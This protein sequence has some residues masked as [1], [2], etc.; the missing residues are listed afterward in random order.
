MMRLFGMTA[1]V[2]M[3]LSVPLSV[4]ADDIPP[5][6]EVPQATAPVVAGPLIHPVMS[7]EQLLCMNWCQLEQL[8]RSLK[9]GPMPSGYYRGTVIYGC[10]KMFPK[11]ASKLAGL[12]WKGKHYDL[13]DCTVV[14]QWLVTKAVRARL[15]YGPSRFDGNSSV[16]MDYSGTCFPRWRDV[17][18]ELREVA[19]GLYLGA[20]FYHSRPCSGPSLYFVLETK[21]CGC[22]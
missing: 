1:T 7:K 4:R 3:I 18:D 21:G 5:P 13:C 2:L 14:N 9:P 17:R 19:P 11:L 12:W 20:M 10:D 16:I 22:H 6:T 8:Y 15:S